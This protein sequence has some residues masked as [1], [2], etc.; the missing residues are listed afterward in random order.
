MFPVGLTS[1]GDF[2]FAHVAGVGRATRR[3][4]ETSQRFASRSSL[5]SVELP[6]GLTS[7]G[8]NAFASCSSL[9]SVELPAGLTSIGDNV[10]C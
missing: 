10:L 1:I 7:I 5:A 3:P 6:A 9:A 8:D 2:A 4:D